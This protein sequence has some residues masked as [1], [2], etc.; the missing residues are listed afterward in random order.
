LSRYQKQRS[1]S[2]ASASL[3]L[4]DTSSGK[5]E[6]SIP[7]R[8]RIPRRRIVPRRRRIV[9]RR[10]RGRIVPRRRIVVSRWRSIIVRRWRIVAWGCQGSPYDRTGD[11]AAKRGSSGSVSTAIIM[12]TIGIGRC[13]YKEQKQNAQCESLN[14]GG[15]AAFHKSL[16][17]NVPG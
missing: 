13:G 4:R 9:S 15:D 11:K 7:R 1:R 5:N 3:Q 2:N 17:L 12:A 14:S 8:N 16:C 6:T 10:G